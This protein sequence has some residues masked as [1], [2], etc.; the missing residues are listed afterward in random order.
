MGDFNAE[1]NSIAYRM[2]TEAGFTSTYKQVHGSEPGKTFPT[3][4]QAEFMDTDPAACLDYIFIKGPSITPLSVNIMGDQAHPNDST[5]YPSD[6]MAL[7]AE[8]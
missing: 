8:F 7:V 2:I 4:L 1:P 3:G 5:I 6:H